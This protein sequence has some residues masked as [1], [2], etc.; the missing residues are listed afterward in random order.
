MNNDL[1]YLRPNIQV[2]PLLRPTAVIFEPVGGTGLPQ[3]A[4]AAVS[5]GIG[6]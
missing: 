3:V 4:R 6:E 2:E 1:L 5:A